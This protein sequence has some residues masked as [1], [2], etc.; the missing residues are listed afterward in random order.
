M[1]ITSMT[2]KSAAAGLLMAV[3]GPAM[4]ENMA[5][6]TMPQQADPQTYKFELVGAPKPLNAKQHVVTVR[7]MRAMQGMHDMA[8]SG[9]V[10]TK[11]QLDMSPDNMPPMTAPVSEIPD[12]ATGAYSFAFDNSVWAD[13]GHWALN[14]TVTVPGESQTVTGRVVFQ[15]GQ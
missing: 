10:I 5:G 2:F 8:V 15:T 14:L 6:H 13:R 12:T 11:A 4:A 7:L 9:A 1:H 3:L